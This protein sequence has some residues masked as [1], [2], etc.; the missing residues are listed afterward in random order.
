MSVFMGG[1]VRPV[2]AVM[3]IPAGG[4]EAE[5]LASGE[6]PLAFGGLVV[7]DDGSIFVAA[8]TLMPGEGTLVKI[9]P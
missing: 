4:G 9:T 5:M 3:A 7:A 2:G 1:D 8:N 6:Q